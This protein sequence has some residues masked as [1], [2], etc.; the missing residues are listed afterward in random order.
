M[1]QRAILQESKFMLSQLRSVHII[2]ERQK[3]FTIVLCNKFQNIN[4]IARFQQKNI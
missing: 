2:N 3:P 4:Y 1:I